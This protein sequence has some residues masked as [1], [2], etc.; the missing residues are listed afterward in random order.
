MCKMYSSSPINFNFM[1]RTDSPVDIL[2]A[3]LTQFC[4]GFDWGGALD[5]L[6][7]VKESPILAGKGLSETHS[8][9]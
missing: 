4:A 3:V 8:I 7:G 5:G 6:A 2:R 1:T 9:E